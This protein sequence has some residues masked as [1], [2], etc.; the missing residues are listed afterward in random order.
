MLKKIALI[1]STE[2]AGTEVVG[3]KVCSALRGMGLTTTMMN[4]NDLKPSALRSMQLIV[5]GAPTYADDEVSDDW[6]AYE[7]QL[8]GLDLTGKVVALYGLGDQLQYPDSF[9]DSM[10][11]VYRCVRSSGAEVIGEWPTIGYRF[12]KSKAVS[13]DGSMF[14][15][16]AL[17]EP[18]Q[19]LLT[20]YRIA[21]W[22]AYI[23]YAFTA[24]KRNGKRDVRF[25][26]S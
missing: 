3:S 18:N 19:A 9:L 17:D 14:F 5:M 16:L 10:G 6:A 7:Y 20:D 25:K 2:S 1:Y 13:E 24:F 15:G 11:G 12:N 26:T 23:S 8:R 4:I 22:V 21:N